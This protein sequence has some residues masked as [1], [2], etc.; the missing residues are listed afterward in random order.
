MKKKSV[1]LALLLAPLAAMAQ[2]YKVVGTLPEGT[3]VVYFKNLESGRDVAPDSLMAKDCPGGRFTFEGDAEGKMFARLYTD[4]TEL[5]NMYVVL[6]GTLNADLAAGT[7]KGTVENKLLGEWQ[8]KM[9]P[10]QARAMAVRKT[11][12]DNREHMTDSLLQQLQGEMEEVGKESTDLALQACRENPDRIFPIV[13]LLSSYY[14]M[15]RAD[16]LALA[17]ADP[18]YLKTSYGQRMA[19][20]IEG[21]RKQMP[22][23]KFTDLEEPDTTGAV[24][25]LGEFVGRG[26]YVLVDFWASWC[27]PCRAELPTVKKA[28][29]QYHSKGFDV[30]GLSFDGDKAAWIGAIDKEKLPWH[31]LS[32]LKGW[33]SL[34]GKVYGITSIPAT[35]FVGPDGTIVANGLRGEALLDKLKEIYGE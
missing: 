15:D 23:V 16:V 8:A 6:D 18:A 28:Y 20:V 3:Q 5:P 10:L 12:M 27:G 33:D 32:D 2:P 11:Y 26:N 4:R 25:K 21:W 13:Y 17:D 35:L 24:R 34:A 7:A 22:G 30:V 9:T 1:L 31:H 29:E 19:N 14:Q